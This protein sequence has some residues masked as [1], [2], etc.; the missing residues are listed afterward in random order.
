MTGHIFDFPWEVA[1]IEWM[2]AHL[3]AGA[4]S[5]ISTFSFFGENV[6]LI[7]LIGFLYWGWNKE[8]GKYVALNTLTAITWNPMIKNIALRL[9]PYMAHEQIKILRVVE[10]SADPM[11]IAAQGYSFP[12]GHATAS[13]AALGSVARYSRDRILTVIA[14]VI[15]LLVG[16]SRFTVG[17]HYPTDVLVGYL[18]GIVALFLVPFLR[19]KIKDERV[20]FGVLLLTTVPGFFYC[21][22]GDYFTGIGMLVGVM[23]ATFFEQRFVRFE[24]TRNPIRIVI[25]IV[26]GFAVYIVF[27]TVLKLPFSSEFLDS[28]TMAA[29]LVRFCRYA[30][31][32]FLMFGVY[33]MTFHLLDRF[34]AKA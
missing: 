29:F 32:S 16:I 6:F 2:Q 19:K 11:D 17:A 23:I 22:S 21:K 3:S 15:P 5:V 4:I 30:I 12:S 7:A 28:A 14:I 33:P 26:C 10:P 27:N 13:T 18:N 34:F 31:I 1:L 24:N 9:R 8:F 25:R 20:F